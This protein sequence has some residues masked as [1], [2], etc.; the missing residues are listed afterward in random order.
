MKKHG[1]KCEKIN[2]YDKFPSEN[3]FFCSCEIPSALIN[4][5]TRYKK[6]INIITFV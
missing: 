4:L 5:K 6:S 2:F 1:N 3:G